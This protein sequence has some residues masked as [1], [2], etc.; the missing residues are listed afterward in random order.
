MRTTLT[1]DEDVLDK[2]RAVAGQLRVPLKTVVNEALRV[3]LREVEKPAKQRP[4]R[5]KPR[6]MGLRKGYSL[7]NIQDLLAQAEGEDFR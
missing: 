7:D 3:G 4:Y 5:T 6:A 2:A 1:L